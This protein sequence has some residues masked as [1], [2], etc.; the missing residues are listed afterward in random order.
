[1]VVMEGVVLVLA[2]VLAV[3]VMFPRQLMSGWSGRSV[4]T[5]GGDQQGK[6]F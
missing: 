6:S 1:M 5:R 2:G 3:V 4:K